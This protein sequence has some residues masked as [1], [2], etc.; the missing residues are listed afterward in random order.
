MGAHRA[1]HA[2][3]SRLFILVSRLEAHCSSAPVPGRV[4][5][6]SVSTA[7]H[8][9]RLKLAALGC[10]VQPAPSHSMAGTAGQMQ[11]LPKKEPINCT[12]RL[13]PGASSR[14]PHQA[15]LLT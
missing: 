12:P 4:A 3:Q 13:C 14:V 10:P 6:L 7:L 8:T 9:L 2:P 5:G 15:A 11:A 1:T